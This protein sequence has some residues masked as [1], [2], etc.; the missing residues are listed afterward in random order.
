MEADGDVIIL[1]EEV[2]ALGGVFTVTRGLQQRFGR[3]RVVDSPICENALVGWA[4]GVAVE[5]FRPVVEIMFSDFSLLAFDQLV[6]LAAKLSYMSNGQFSVPLVIRMPG[7]AGTNHG[8]Q[9]SQ[10][11]ESM[12]AHVPGLVVAMPS[13]ATDAYTMMRH[14]IRCDDPV[15]FLESKY[16]YFREAANVDL[17]AELCGFG[18]RVARSGQDV[19]LVS[20]SRMVQRSLEVAELLA[21]EG[22]SCEVIDLR[23]LWPLDTATIAASVERTGKL[24]VVHEPTEFGGWGGEV[25]GWI[26][27]H[28][29]EQLDA[30]IIRVGARRVPIPFQPHLEDQIVPTAKAIAAEVKALAAY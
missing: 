26:A 30:P 4:V 10:S 12:F 21:K 3:G 2:G 24:A 11:L 17:D 7:G 13:T 6:N 23:Y 18:S 8:P 25:A 1:G 22:V 20:A 19:T 27:Q 28:R 14:A 29:F 5:G 16:L 15:V 9:H